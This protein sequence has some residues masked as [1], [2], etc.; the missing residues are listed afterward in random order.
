MNKTVK[1]GYIMVFTLIII[2]LSTMLIT[3]LS[4]KVRSHIHYTKTAT[5]QEKAKLLALSGLEIAK[6]QLSFEQEKERNK[7]KKEHKNSTIENIKLFIKKIVPSLNSWQN[8]KLSKKSDGING[9][10]QLCI[11]SEEGKININEL[12]SIKDKKFVWINQNAKKIVQYICSEIEKYTKKEK[13]FND[14]ESY[15]KKRKNK[16]YDVTQLLSIKNMNYFNNNV[17]YEPSNKNE[18]KKINRTE[19]QD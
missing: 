2:S 18:S 10:I 9:Q 4:Y 7:E 15:L 13:L 3:N 19:Q 16:L 14:I 8:F 12:F 6:S 17:F 11:M 1:S 5:I